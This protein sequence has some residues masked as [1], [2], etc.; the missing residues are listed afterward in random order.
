[1]KRR[2]FLEMLWPAGALKATDTDALAA[3][4]ADLV[5]RDL[6]TQPPILMKQLFA[7]GRHN[8]VARL[9]ELA[10]IPTLILSGD[11][12]P[13]ALPSHG[14]M[15]AEAI[16]G[17]GFELVPNTSHG[18]TIHRSDEVNQRLKAFIDSVE[19][20]TPAAAI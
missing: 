6:A 18:M 14:K 13:I 19:S 20:R 16:P 11:R 7:M 9:K 10:A 4:V 5:G 3:R 15:L 1:M 17:A 12:D 2:A 8:A